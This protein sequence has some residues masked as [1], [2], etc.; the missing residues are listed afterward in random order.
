MSRK[1][2]YIVVALSLA[3]MV[4]AGCAQEPEQV[5]VTR[6]VIETV[7]SEPETVEV[8][9]T[10]EVEVEVVQE[11]EVEVTRIVEVAAEV[12][13]E[14][15]SEAASAAGDE[16]PDYEEFLAD[17]YYVDLAG[18]VTQ[19][20]VLA[21]L[22]EMTGGPDAVVLPE[23]I[24][25]EGF[26]ALE[27]I[28]TAVHM[29]NMDELGYS[30][31]EEKA[32][33]ALQDWTNLPQDLELARKQELAAAVDSGLLPADL[34]GIDLQAPVSAE[35]AADMMGRVLE[36]TGQYKHFLGS[37]EDPDIYSDVLYFWNSFDQV[38]KPDLQEP[39]NEMIIDGVITG[40]N[41]K[42]LAND[43]MADPDNTII[44]GHSNIDHAM[45][46][47]ALMRSE[48][49]EADVQLEPKTSAY[50]YLA[51]WGEPTES[52]GFQVDPLDDG[53]YIAF[54]KEYDLVFEF[55][56]PADKE[57]FDAVIKQYAKKNEA[58]Q[59]GLILGSWWQPLYSSTEPIE[60][61]VQV[62]N[63]VAS[64]EGYFIQSFSLPD[65]QESVD[66]FAAA[67][68]DSQ[69][70]TVDT[71]VNQAFHNYMLGESQ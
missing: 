51:D 38:S 41:V 47:I 12:V 35:L 68:P 16:S 23:E 53:N 50:L 65:N 15:M 52:P 25:S 40:Y 22:T 4:L 62:I 18:D 55:E 48:D 17:R 6:V 63:N 56:D 46:L 21:A 9:V 8:E 33:A 26:T 10:R 42:R 43:S 58:D 19:E 27:L 49:L 61:Y 39:A 69:V 2:V 14:D 54:A 70:D 3:L 64:D 45:Q 24:D 57:Q 20:Q 60:E 29:A 28:L 32:D 67:F 11:V 71:W 44:Y 30:Y 31:P 37:T 7:Q 36:V 5:E 59:P 66:Q 13:E 1:F 34:N